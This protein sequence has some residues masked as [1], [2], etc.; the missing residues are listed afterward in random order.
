MDVDVIK[1]GVQ[2]SESDLDVSEHGVQASK[3]E[4]DVP[5]TSFRYLRTAIQLPSTPAVRVAE[6]SETLDALISKNER[7]ASA[8]TRAA[9]FRY[10]VRRV[11]RVGRRTF[12]GRWEPRIP[13]CPCTIGGG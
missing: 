5:R 1:T 11:V 12:G 4:V 8:L 10:A 6:H 9:R 7:T 13:S 3:T 2:G